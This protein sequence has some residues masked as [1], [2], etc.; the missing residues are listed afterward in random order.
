[1]VGAEVGNYL[2]MFRGKLY[3]RFPGMTRRIATEEERDEIKK[4]LQVTWYH[5]EFRLA[6]SHAVYF[7]IYLKLCFMTWRFIYAV[8][9]KNLGTII[10]SSIDSKIH[11]KIALF[12]LIW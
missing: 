12:E 7:Q 8:I 4:V 2:R 11:E 6:F 5:Q 1:M 10:F 3:K 9:G